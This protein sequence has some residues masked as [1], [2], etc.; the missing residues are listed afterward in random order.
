MVPVEGAAVHG[1]V[2]SVEDWGSEQ[3][4]QVR[5]PGAGEREH[6]LGDES[7]DERLLDVRV[8]S[9]QRYAIG[10][11]VGLAIDLDSACI[12]DVQ[13]GQSLSREAGV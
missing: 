1:E 6:V 10:E 4:V 13:S 7:R 9:R 2:V 8:G 11:R 5:L 3:L 12:F